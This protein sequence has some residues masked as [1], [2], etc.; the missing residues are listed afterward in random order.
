MSVKMLN[1]NWLNLS[2]KLFWGRVQ[3]KSKYRRNSNT[4]II[5]AQFLDKVNEQKGQHQGVALIS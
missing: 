5:L 4:Q 3:S 1:S 2:L